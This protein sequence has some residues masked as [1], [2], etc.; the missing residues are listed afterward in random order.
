M[1]PT[2]RVELFNADVIETA[3][4]RWRETTSPAEIEAS[5]PI[6]FASCRCWVLFLSC[7]DTALIREYKV[8]LYQHDHKPVVVSMANR[9]TFTSKTCTPLKVSSLF[10]SVGLLKME[11]QLQRN[12]QWWCDFF[13]YS[14]FPQLWRIQNNFRSTLGKPSDPS[15]LL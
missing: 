2:N 13:V 4:A 6:S 9:W 15:I 11:L 3:V 12:I 5:L 7:G 14:D 1:S 8:A 10:V